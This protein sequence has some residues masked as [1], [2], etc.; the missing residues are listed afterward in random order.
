MYQFY[1]L[2]YNNRK[3]EKFHNEFEDKNYASKK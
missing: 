2:S 1:Y 3:S